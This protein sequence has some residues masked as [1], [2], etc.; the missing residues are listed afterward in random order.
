MK[1]IISLLMMVT[2]L[3]PVTSRAA[4]Y[5]LDPEKTTIQFSIKNLGFITVKGVFKKFR[6]TVTVDEA[7]PAKSKADVTIDVASI[8]TGID[9]RD[10]DLRGA[11][12]F[13]AEKFPA[14]TFVAT[15]VEPG[16][17]A[18]TLTGN[19]TIKGVTKPVTLAVQG[20]TAVQGDA[21]LAATATTTLN[22]KDFGVS[23]GATI[24]DT[25]AVTIK[26]ELVKQ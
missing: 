17:G 18:L 25:L 6:G 13:D 10:K 19:L 23:S 3:A 5:A 1:Q 15:R 9:L 14:M 21:R 11:S 4:N 8:S 12:F 7:E 20:P 26:A 16:S 2:L 24:A 22:R